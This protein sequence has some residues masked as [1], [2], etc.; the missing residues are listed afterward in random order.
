MSEFLALELQVAELAQRALAA[1]SSARTQSHFS[2]SD[3]KL[4]PGPHLLLSIYMCECV[5]TS[6]C[7]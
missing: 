6:M 1:R 5:D 2:C 3:T 4:G 7:V